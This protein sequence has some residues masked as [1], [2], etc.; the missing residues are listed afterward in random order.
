MRRV[1]AA[2]LALALVGACG[3]SGDDDGRISTR[4]TTT[5]RADAANTTTASDATTTSAAG[6]TTTT[7]RSGAA[8]TGPSSTNATAPVVDRVAAV[9]MATMRQPIA[10]ALRAGDDALYIAEK[11]GR[12]RRMTVSGNTATLEGT[13]L[14]INDRISTGN[15][16]GLLGIAFS[17]DGARFYASYTNTTG[18]TRV[19]EFPFSN[20]AVVKSVERVILAVD[21]P[22]PNHNGGQINFGADG[23]LY[24]ALGDGGAGGDPQGYAQNLNTLLGKILRIQVTP[25]GNPPYTIPGDNPL[26]GQAGRRGEIWHYGLRNPWRWSFDRA[27]GEQWIADVGQNAYEEVNHIAAGRKGVNFGWVNREGKHAYNGG[28]KPPGA[29]DPEYELTHD[30]GNCS[31]TGGFVY[32]GSQIRGLAGSYVFADYC[33]GRITAAAGGALRELGPQIDEVSSFGQDASGELW[34]FSLAGGVSRLD[35]A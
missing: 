4:K 34:V 23:M 24:V 29:V 8:T 31:V 26:V 5:T 27:T 33:R 30:D 9:R 19:V 13:I 15:E 11:G 12:V 3:G 16:Q 1:L 14:D 17:P 20:G 28:S 22:Y 25:S 32:R 21:Q 2:G 18:D 10:M 35:R 7:R 6:A